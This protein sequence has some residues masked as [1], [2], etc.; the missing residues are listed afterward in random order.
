MADAAPLTVLDRQR[1]ALVDAYIRRAWNMWKSLDPAD[2]WNDAVTQ[3]VGA[4][5]TQNQ[6]AFVKAMRRLGISYADVMLRTVGTTPAGQIP[7]YTVVRD[8]TDPWA[9]SLRPV[10]EYRG[11]AVRDPSIRP[12]AWDNL[13]KYAQKAV[14]EWL[15]HAMQRLETNAQTDGTLAVNSATVERFHGSGVKRYRR[16]I[17][18]ELTRTG[19]CG[20]CVVAATNTFSTGDLL[21]MH[22]N[23]VCTV[24]PITADSDPGLDLNKDDL[25]EIYRAAGGSTSASAL[26]QLR[27]TVSEHSELGPI[28]TQK[29]WRGKLDDGSPAPA[30]HRPDRNMTRTQMGR[31]LARAE[32]FQSHYL[33]VMETGREDEFRFE[34]RSYRFKP[35]GHLEQALSYQTAWLKWLRANYVPAA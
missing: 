31:M 24:A 25:K 28:L 22:N 19:T 32:A 4:W 6:I 14:T 21:P 2:W 30:W 27:V 33:K 18:P 15:D 29:E 8:N 20:L 34:G 26:K 13:D 1:Q 16:V 23:C 3:G 17:H 10:D 9:V 11:L 12:Q 5:I 35:S 7:E